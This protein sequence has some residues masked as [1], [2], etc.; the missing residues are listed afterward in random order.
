MDRGERLIKAANSSF[1]EKGITV[2]PYGP[3]GGKEIITMGGD[4]KF[5]H[6]IKT[7]NTST[8]YK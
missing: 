4:E 7:M 1:F 8:G 5:I 6:N 3:T 2:P